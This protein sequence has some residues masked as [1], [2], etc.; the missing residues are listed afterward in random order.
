LRTV[1]APGPVEASSL[2]S[3]E[4]PKGFTLVTEV[5]SN[6]EVDKESWPKRRSL[7]LPATFQPLHM[8][9]VLIVSQ[10][11]CSFFPRLL[12]GGPTHPMLEQIRLCLIAYTLRRFARVERSSAA[13]GQKCHSQFVKSQ[14]D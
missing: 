10:C 9:A 3:E 5:G 14:L 7:A 1:L 13:K 8:A 2:L 11:R 12:I 4:I 6:K